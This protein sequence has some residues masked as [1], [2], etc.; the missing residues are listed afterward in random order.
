MT[1]LKEDGEEVFEPLQVNKGVSVLRSQSL[2]VVSP[3]TLANCLPSGLNETHRT[4]SA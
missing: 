1:H 3:E 2:T 4:A